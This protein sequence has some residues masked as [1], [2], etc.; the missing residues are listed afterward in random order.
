MSQIADLVQRHLEGIPDLATM[1]REIARV[2]KE[3]LE[4]ERARAKIVAV[5]IAVKAARSG[6]KSGL[7]RGTNAQIMFDMIA[8]RGPI[9]VCELKR[10]L[11]HGG[12]AEASTYSYQSIKFLEGKGLIVKQKM[13]GGQVYV[14]VAPQ[15]E[16]GNNDEDSD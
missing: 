10:A 3:L 13:P 1:D 14:Q 5:K 2:K 9:R 7:R 12:E 8:A 15:H 6:K 4:L 16:E 11:F